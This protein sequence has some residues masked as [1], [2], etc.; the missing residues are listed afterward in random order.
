[1]SLGSGMLNNLLPVF[2][3][4]P[5]VCVCMC[6]HSLHDQISEL[7]RP[8]GVSGVLV[9]KLSDPWKACS[10]LY[11]TLC[12]KVS[13][14]KKKASSQWCSR[15]TPIFIHPSVFLTY[16][17]YPPPPSNWVYLLCGLIKSRKRAFAQTGFLTDFWCLGIKGAQQVDLNGIGLLNII[18]ST[19][20]WLFC[21]Y[22]YSYTLTL[23][24]AVIGSSPLWP[25]KQ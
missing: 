9:D 14:V 19:L 11:I 10:F 16:P 6:E 18:T 17:W 5:C 24:A 25:I 15:N 8:R 22:I 7:S 2:R 21:L 23:K 3:P 12:W 13:S 20:I 4:C 1:M